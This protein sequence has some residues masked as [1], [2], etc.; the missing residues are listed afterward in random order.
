MPGP[1]PSDPQLR[2]RR[3]RV[4]TAGVIDAAPARKP[5]LGR[6]RPDG[7]DW[8]RETLRWWRT[9][10]ASAI[11]ERWVDAHVG[12]L[13]AMAR[14]FDDF[15]KATTPAE[16]KQIHAEFRQA[17]REFGLTPFAARSMG[18]EFRRPQASGPEPASPLPPGADPRKMLAM[19]ARRR[20]G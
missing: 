18:W 7:L 14:L 11:A 13:R 8:H 17:A 3:N 1:L 10:W 9:I 2:Q 20:A 4:S 5:S 19:P 15:W 12:G 6:K 16:A